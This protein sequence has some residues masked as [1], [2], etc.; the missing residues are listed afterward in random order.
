MI[1]LSMYIIDVKRTAIGRFLGALSETNAI[2]IALPLFNFFIKKYP[3]L[4]NE[5]DEIILGNV[6]STGLGQN[7]ARKISYESGISKL[8]PAFTINHVC[9]SGL[10]SIIQGFKSIKLNESDIVI[11]GGVES[12][13]NA[14][15]YLPSY[16]KGNKLGNGDVID[17]L[18]HDGLYC[19][20]SNMTMAETADI[21]AKKYGVSREEQDQ[22]AY[23]S[24][25]KAL[26]AQKNKFFDNEIVPIQVHGK[27]GLTEFIIDE[28]PRSDTSIEKLAKLKPLNRSEGTITAGNASGINDGAALCLLASERLVNK[29]QLKPMAKIIEY[30]YI[31]TDPELMGLGAY[32]SIKRLL[33]KAKMNINKIDLFEINEAFAAQALRV[34]NLLNINQENVNING[35]AIALGHPLGASGARILTTL[36]YN[37][38]L[39]KTTL[40]VASLCI[41]GGQGVSIL[42]QKL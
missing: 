5:T 30:D 40:G 18:T 39:T 8:T 19:S 29:Y 9:G 32:Y 17:S 15:H 38:L 23:Y 34:I 14:V 28:Q 20:L 33:I 16:R 42:V 2:D 21:L 27:T 37:L 41:G 24:H 10:T 25:Q 3:F 4:I 12:M 1:E 11:C 6:L 36:I 35:G 31:G 26:T 7:I 22:Y 13:S